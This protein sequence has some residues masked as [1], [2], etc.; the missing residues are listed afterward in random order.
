MGDLSGRETWLRRSSK[1]GTA[2]VC[3]REAGATPRN[4]RQKRRPGMSHD[5]TYQTRST[6]LTGP[7]S[8]PLL[9]TVL[10]RKR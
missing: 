4:P 10:L 7:L 1:L 5:L 3:K 2:W 8:F 9:Y 6:R